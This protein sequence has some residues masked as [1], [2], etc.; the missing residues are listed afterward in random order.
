V[1]ISVEEVQQQEKEAEEHKTPEQL[2]KELQ[3]LQ[4]GLNKS[5]WVHGH[6]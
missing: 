3:D 1:Q 4:A 6:I 5:R 2:R